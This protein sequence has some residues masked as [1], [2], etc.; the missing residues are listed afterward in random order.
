M[1]ALYSAFHLLLVAIAALILDRLL[2][3]PRHH[4]L[5]VFSNFASWMEQRLNNRKSITR[6]LVSVII[7]LAM[8]VILIWWL[9]ERLSNL[10]VL[11][12]LFE[13]GVLYFV[14]GWQ[15]LKQ[16][17]NAIYTPLK[18]GHLPAAREALS[19]I[20]S[21]QTERM[22]LPQI[23]GSTIE[24]Q[25]E[26]GLDCAFASLFWFAVLGP[27]GALLHRLVNTLDAMWGYKN[28]R[29]F[30]FGRFAARTDD[31][32]AWIPA[33]LTA[34]AYA[35]AGNTRLGLRS[36]REQAGEHISP[37]GGVVMATGA[38]ALHCRIGGPQV[39]QGVLVDKPWLGTGELAR[40]EHI[41]LATKLI[42]RSLLIWLL[43]FAMVGAA[44]L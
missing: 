15:S 34:L 21:R 41:D 12:F 37:N 7:V 9:H 35:L 25:L 18:K 8:P 19:M 39:Y 30:K 5:V 36:W 24:S 4:P 27:A 2:G 32:M 16:H 20:V 14:I 22:E 11:S 33:R 29:Y 6:G 44:N 43:I 28:Q 31:L 40:V 10:P 1:T 13:V 23:V 38:G 26:N 42:E 17:T 3:E